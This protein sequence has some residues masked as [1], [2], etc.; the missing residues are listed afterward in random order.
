MVQP[1]CLFCFVCMVFK[2][3]VLLYCG[4]GS[5]RQGANEGAVQWLSFPLRF[6][7]HFGA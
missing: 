7:A 2:H 4:K 5:G 6:C 1:R 3:E